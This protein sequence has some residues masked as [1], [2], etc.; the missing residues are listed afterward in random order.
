MITDI[1][2]DLIDETFEKEPDFYSGLMALALYRYD[3]VQEK[4]TEAPTEKGRARIMQ[5]LVLTA[6]EDINSLGYGS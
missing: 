2:R 3:I 1:E 4:R 6:Y 5:D